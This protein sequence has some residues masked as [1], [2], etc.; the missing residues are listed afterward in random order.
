MSC[1]ALFLAL[2]KCLSTTETNTEFMSFLA[3]LIN[4]TSTSN[5]TCAL[6]APSS[7]GGGGGKFPEPDG[8]AMGSS[9]GGGGGGRKSPMERKYTKEVNRQEILQYS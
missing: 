7:R 5:L 3:L 2:D 4:M 1:E 8:R 9:R 6:K